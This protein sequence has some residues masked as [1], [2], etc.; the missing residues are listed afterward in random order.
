M[1]V[2]TTLICCFLGLQNPGHFACHTVCQSLK[3]TVLQE[4]SFTCKAAKHVDK[5][6][7]VSNVYAPG[8]GLGLYMAEA[9][10]RVIGS[11]LVQS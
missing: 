6:E 1:F 2:S 8:E 11:N 10:E 7:Q 4:T 9:R 3:G 5:E